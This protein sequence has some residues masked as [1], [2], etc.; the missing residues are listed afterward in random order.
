[1]GTAVEG[2]RRLWLLKLVEALQAEL[3]D[4]EDEIKTTAAMILE[5]GIPPGRD[6]PL[7]RAYL[8]Q[9]GESAERIDQLI[10]IIR[11]VRNRNRGLEL[12]AE[13]RPA[14]PQPLPPEIPRYTG[15][16]WPP[17]Q[18]EEEALVA[19]ALE[20]LQAVT[21]F[22]QLAP[23]MQGAQQ[24]LRSLRVAVAAEA[25]ESVRLPQLLAEW[26]RARAEWEV[27]E[28]ALHTAQ[29]TLRRT[30]WLVTYLQWPPIE[31]Y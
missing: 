22:K 10:R 21:L 15:P 16:T 13:P 28:Q 14:Q 2:A 19:E 7:L 18:P 8:Q 29:A 23:R 24:Q 1:M 12:E 27:Q 3:P 11:N 17:E 30:E 20:R 26:Q 6:E 5:H 25:D 4:G 31:N 9:V